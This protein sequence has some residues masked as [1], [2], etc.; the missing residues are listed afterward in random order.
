MGVNINSFE[1][2]KIVASDNR[3]V[4]E[5]LGNELIAHRIPRLLRYADRNSMRFSVESRVPF[6]TT[7]MT[8]FLLSL[9]ESYLI[10]NSGQSKYIFRNA[11]KGIVPIEILERKDKIGFETPEKELLKNI[12]PLFKENQKVIEN[13]PF[14]NFKKL[15]QQFEEGFEKNPHEIKLF[16]RVINL[17]LWIKIFDVKI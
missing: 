5:Q 10:S 1:K 3:R 14:I 11:L 17:L 13:F 4:V 9:P 2:K 7:E 15:N 12:Y 16:W 8:D 6:L